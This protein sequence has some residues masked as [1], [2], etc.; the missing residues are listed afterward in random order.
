MSECYNIF[1]DF[2]C[3]HSM[4][5]V[6]VRKDSRQTSI[7]KFFEVLEVAKSCQV[8]VNPQMVRKKE[9]MDDSSYIILVV[10]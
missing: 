3:V 4:I 6:W 1:L 9:S 2:D 5:L 8:E 7:E 10:E